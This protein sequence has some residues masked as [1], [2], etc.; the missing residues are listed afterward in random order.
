MDAELWAAR[1]TAAKRHHAVHYNTAEWASSRIVTDRHFGFDDL[2]GDDDM[3]ADFTCPFCYEDFDITL[4]CYH[5]EDEHCLE[6]KNVV[7]PVCAVKVGR[8]MVGHITLQHG[9]LFKM[10]RRRRF[11]KGG[12]A[13]NSTHP[14]LG[15]E[16]REGQLN[17]LLGSASS[18]VVSAS[19]VAPDPLLSSFVYNLS[20]SETSD[21]QLKPSMSLEE[22]SMKN[23]PDVQVM[24]SADSSL[25]MEER[26]HKFEE[27][28]RRA[29]F[30]QQLLLST[31]M[32][33][34]L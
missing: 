4:L 15:K 29:A 23:S 30:V 1:V 12:I 7:C 14:F 17:P 20:V 31:I 34:N 27:E 28:R 33:E 18:C 21:E 2:E 25:T 32:G 5:L 19:S 16:F 6:T 10:Q 11:R 24:A 3:R 8:D 22:N 13:S 26:E 9:H